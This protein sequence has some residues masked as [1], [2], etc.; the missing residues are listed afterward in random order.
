[1]NPTDISDA[2]GDSTL[3]PAVTPVSPPAA[4]STG[5][6]ADVGGA[7]VSADKTFNFETFDKEFDNGETVD[8]LANAAAPVQPPALPAV[9]PALAAKPVVETPKVQEAIAPVVS[10]AV[11]TPIPPVTPVV[12]EAVALVPKPV[13]PVV[14][15]P[16]VPAMS[17]EQIAAERVRVTQQYEQSYAMTEDEGSELIRSPETVLP[18]LAARMHVQV[19]ETTLTIVQQMLPKLL[20]RELGVANQAQK[21]RADFFVSWPELDKPNFQET[22][23]RVSN[24]YRA[25]NPGASVEQFI[26]EV[27]ATASMLLKVPPKS[28]M[29]EQTPVPAL[30][31]FTP[32]SPGGGGAPLV[33]AQQLN[34][35][36]TMAVEFLEADKR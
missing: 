18:K 20:E 29:Q 10:P 24:L 14:T 33:P 34:A 4:G 9:V 7:A 5:S 26:Q 11:V 28:M 35:F 3:V 1:M 21:A 13:E 6:A 23:Q 27:G 31:A 22:L 25:N 17:A 16:P 19:M 15:Q 32:A 30:V 12:P 36:E 2:L 8:V